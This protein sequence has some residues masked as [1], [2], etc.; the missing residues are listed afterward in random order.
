MKKVLLKGPILTRSGYGEQARFAYRSLMSRPDLYDVYIQPITWGQTSWINE[1]TPE[2]VMIDGLIEKT[3]FYLQ[4]GGIFDIELQVTIPNEWEKNNPQTRVVGYTAGIETTQVT[5]EWLLKANQID[6]IICVS[7]H[8]KNVFA[9]T[10]YRAQ[11]Q[12]GSEGPMLKLQTPIEAVGYPVKEYESAD[13]QLDTSTDFNFLCV[14]Q[15]GPRKNVENTIKWFVDEFKEEN[16]GLILKTNLAKNCHIDREICWNKIQEIF[17]QS[18]GDTP[19]QCKVYLLHGDM[20]DEEIHSLYTHPNVDAYISLSHG[21]GFG[22]PIF[23]AAYSGLPIIT[24]PWSGHVDFLKSDSV[25]EPFYNVAFDIGQVPPVAVWDGV[26]LAESGWCYPR[27]HS[28]QMCM[29]ECYNDLTSENRETVLSAA[30]QHAEYLKEQFADE[31]M[32]NKFLSATDPDFQTESIL[33]EVDIADIPK[34]SLVTSVYKANDYIEQLMEDVTRQT[35]FEEK[36]EWVIL[37]VDPPGEEFDEEVI[38][39]YVEKYPNNIV[40]QRLDEDPGIYDTWNM[41]I[42]MSTGEYVTNVNCDD[43]RRADGLEQQARLL[44]AKQDVDLVYNDSYIVHEPNVMFEDVTAG[45]QRY[46]FEQFSKEAMLRGNQP[47]NNPMWRRELHDKYGYFN[48]YYKAS[49]DWDFWL[50]CAFG[51]AVFAKHPEILG[52][53]YFNP[54]GMSTNPE[55][56]AWKREH[57]KEIFQGYLQIY[58][59]QQQ[60]TTQ[61]LSL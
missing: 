34:I 14:A 27:A 31:V 48:Q 24:S 17:N 44:V 40:Y 12:D 49:G 55:H 35:I 5:S 38:L 21:E 61:G 51:G 32:Y 22:L 36:C 28:A 19:P 39:K 46:N 1:D 25:D 57:E 20:T 9:D 52:V 26:V 37:N 59:Q 7:A 42:Q 45:C 8:S 60:H 56:D 6:S 30:A 2:R 43:R 53:Y 50:R 41:G 29:R 13:I 47:H 16:V 58:Q 11:N 18:E 10:Q 33:D 3:I 23:E 54:V 15:W 4:Q